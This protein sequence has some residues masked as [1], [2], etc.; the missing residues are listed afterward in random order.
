[1]LEKLK[2][3]ADKGLLAVNPDKFEDLMSDLRVA[4]VQGRKLEK[5]KASNQTMDL[6]DALRL[7]TEYYDLD[8][9]KK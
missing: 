1:M 8:T 3:F 2:D 9:T 4:R 6:L 5:D 7:S